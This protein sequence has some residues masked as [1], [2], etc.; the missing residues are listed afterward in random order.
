MKNNGFHRSSPF[1]DGWVEM[2][3]DERQP[4]CRVGESWARH[5]QGAGANRSAPRQSA[6]QDAKGRKERKVMITKHL[7]FI[8]AISLAACS[9]DRSEPKSPPAMTPASDTATSTGREYETPRATTP[10]S[11]GDERLPAGADTNPSE[12][13]S[14]GDTTG[15]MTPADPDEIRSPNSD[16][17]PLGGG[18]G[19][20]G[21]TGGSTTGGTSGGGKGGRGGTSAK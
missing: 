16:P 13:T 11:P 18:S 8:G 14:P 7:L 15:A 5:L 3:Q 4:M 17:Y 1:W 21:G 10:L 19:G 20:L 6:P 2:H 12:G 9:H